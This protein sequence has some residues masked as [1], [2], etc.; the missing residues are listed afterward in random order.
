ME[1]TYAVDPIEVVLAD[2]KVRRLRYPAAALKRL[3]A[4][5]A[6]LGSEATNV[7]HTATT[8]W[9]GLMDRDGIE[10]VECTCEK[11]PCE[12]KSLFGLIDARGIPHIQEQIALALP[13][14][15]NP[16]DPASGS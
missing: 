13:K 5:L 15:Q 1:R 8:L 14:P 2:G 4:A 7:D 11:D 3:A 12:C 10:R 16:P 9:H 6:A